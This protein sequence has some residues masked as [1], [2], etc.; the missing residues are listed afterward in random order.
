MGGAV[1]EALDPPSQVLAGGFSS[2]GS[3]DL[4]LCGSSSPKSDLWLCWE[5]GLGE[6]RAVS[7]VVVPNPRPTG[8]LPVIAIKAVAWG[9]RAAPGTKNSL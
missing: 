7:R 3:H 1:P 4:G 8:E 6:G 5:K 9:L 2:S